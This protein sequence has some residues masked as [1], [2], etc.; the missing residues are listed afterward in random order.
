VEQLLQASLFYSS[1]SK[2]D[3]FPES[4]AAKKIEKLIF[5]QLFVFPL[6]VAA[7]CVT[8]SSAIA[9]FSSKSKDDTVPLTL[10]LLNLPK[11]KV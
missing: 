7:Q 8:I 3:I 10:A 1:K 2:D 11:G 9:F 6:I 4:C 5:Q